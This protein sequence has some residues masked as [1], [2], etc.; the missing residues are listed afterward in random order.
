MALA[1]FAEALAAGSVRMAVHQL[2]RLRGPQPRDGRCFVNVNPVAVRLIGLALLAGAAQPT[3][4]DPPFS[5]WPFQETTLEI[6]VA[7]HRAKALV[8][9]VGQAERIA[10]AQQQRAAPG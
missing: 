8:I 9:G 6:G 4:D 10:V 5:Q 2:A 7:H 1:A 3:A